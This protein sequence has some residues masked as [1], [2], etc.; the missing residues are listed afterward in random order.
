M[1]NKQISKPGNFFSAGFGVFVLAV[2]IVWLGKLLGIV[3]VDF[4]ILKYICPACLIL[5]GAWIIFGRY[6][7]KNQKQL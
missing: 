3:P 7:K 4:D 2:G 5:F 1:D 6:I